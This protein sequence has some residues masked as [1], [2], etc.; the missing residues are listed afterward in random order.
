M[1]FHLIRQKSKTIFWNVLLQSGRINTRNVRISMST[2]R[3]NFF[4]L[5][6]SKLNS[7][8]MDLMH[9]SHFLGVKS[10]NFLVRVEGVPVT[11]EP[12]T[13]AQSTYL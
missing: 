4:D 11:S 1:I 5:K 8:T 9:F 6:K 12:Q 2:I 7:Q 13:H 3:G 10:E